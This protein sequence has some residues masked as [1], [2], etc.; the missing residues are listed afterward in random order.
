[1][2]SFILLIALVVLFA[3]T[4]KSSKNLPDEKEDVDFVV[5]LQFL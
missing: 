1:M 3:A 2:I 5:P 4:W